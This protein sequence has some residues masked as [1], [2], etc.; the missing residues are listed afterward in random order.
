MATTRRSADSGRA[1]RGRGAGLRPVVGELEFELG[2]A[3]RNPWDRP[4][5]FTDPGVIRRRVRVLSDTLHLDEFRVRGWAFAQAVLSAV[6]TIEDE[7]RLDD[8]SARLALAETLRPSVA[9]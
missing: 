1:G 2:A 3:L 6:W 4:S 8:D 9:E 5:L 7:G